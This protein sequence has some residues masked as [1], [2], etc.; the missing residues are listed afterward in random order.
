ML[1][2]LV[3]PGLGLFIGTVAVTIGGGATAGVPLLLLLGHSGAQ[4]IAPSSSRCSAPS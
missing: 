2:M 4:S 1:S 3:L